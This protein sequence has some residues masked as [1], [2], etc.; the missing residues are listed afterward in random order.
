MITINLI[1]SIETF[2]NKVYYMLSDGSKNNRTF[3]LDFETK[4]E[5]INYLKEKNDY[6]K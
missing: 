4:L 5:M 6:I 1:Q 3:S 2:N